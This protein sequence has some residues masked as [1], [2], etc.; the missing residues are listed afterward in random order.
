MVRLNS[1]KTGLDAKIHARLDKL[2]RAQSSN[3]DVVTRDILEDLFDLSTKH[4]VGRAL[5]VVDSMEKMLSQK[6]LRKGIR[7][8]VVKAA[9]PPPSDDVGGD[10][11]DDGDDD[12]GGGGGDDEFARKLKRFS[13]K[14]GVV[15]DLDAMDAV[16]RVHE[17]DPS[18]A[19][20]LVA[21]GIS[22]QRLR[23]PNAFLMVRAFEFDRVSFSSE[24]AHHHIRLDD[25]RSR[26]P[27]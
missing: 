17:I 13:Q 8:V 25:K 15:V 11:D 9:H 24:A 18:Q 3:K 21:E 10:D 27:R 12:D 1:W 2:Y 6:E 22:R 23:N 26:G 7:S 5:E 4:G 14:F 16:N 19:V 20:A